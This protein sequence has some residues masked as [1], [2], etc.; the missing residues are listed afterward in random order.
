MPFT[1]ANLEL[2]REIIAQYPQQE[3]G[4]AAAAAPR[5]G[6]GRSGHARGDGGDRRPA[7]PHARARARDVLLLHDVQAG[8]GR[9][10]AGVGVHQR[11]L[12]GERRPRPPRPPAA[13]L[14]R[15]PRRR[16]SKRSSASRRATS[17]RCCRSTTS[18]TARSPGPTP[19]P[20]HRRVQAGRRAWPRTHLRYRTGTERSVSRWQRHETRIVTKFLRERPDDSWTIDAAL[21]NG[22]YDGLDARRSA[23]RPRTSSAEVRPRACAVAAAPAS[24]PARSGRSCPRTCSRATSR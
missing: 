3:V 18:S 2:A 1:P 19:R 9:E 15:R 4:G 12:P 20:G 14:R 24:A 13:P 8:A 11:E 16:P 22:A 10:A 21:G 7:R 5:A 17:R 23:W 6:P